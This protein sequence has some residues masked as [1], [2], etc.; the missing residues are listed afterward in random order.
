MNT[1]LRNLKKKINYNHK[2]ALSEVDGLDLPTACNKFIVSYA[3]LLTR[4]YLVLYS[5]PNCFLLEMFEIHLNIS[6][7]TAY[8]CWYICSRHK[9]STYPYVLY[10][11]F[12]TT[13]CCPTKDPA[14][15]TPPEQRHS[16]LDIWWTLSHVYETNKET[17]K[18]NTA[19]LVLSSTWLTD[20]K[21]KKKIKDSF[22][23]S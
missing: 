16:D 15:S 8:I 3:T 4:L 17:K 14:I 10:T 21:F 19:R 9:T 12:H 22:S 11:L 5:A 7:S 18:E 2:H 23:K 6:Q 1:G 20:C 13:V